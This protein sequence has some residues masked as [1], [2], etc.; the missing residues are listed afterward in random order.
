MNY[1]ILPINDLKEHEEKSTCECNPRVEF[2]NGNQ[3]IIHNSFDGREGVELAKEVL[4]DELRKKRTTPRTLSDMAHAGD[5]CKCG[6]RRFD[7]ARISSH[8]YTDGK[9]SIPDCKCEWFN[10]DAANKKS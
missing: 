5:L 7:H 9:C 2:I 10:Y 8:N 4:N 1:H 6:H 3:L